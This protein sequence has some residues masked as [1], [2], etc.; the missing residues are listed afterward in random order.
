MPT[1][2]SNITGE[3]PGLLRDNTQKKE[4]KKQNETVD[5]FVDL[6][7]VQSKRLIRFAHAVTTSRVDAT[8][9]SA[10]TTGSERC[11]DGTLRAVTHRSDNR[12]REAGCQR[13]LRRQLTDLVWL[14]QVTGVNGCVCKTTAPTAQRCTTVYNCEQ[15]S[16]SKLR[17]ASPRS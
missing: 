13:L 12:P 8:S 7:E 1:R 3:W 5:K 2:S 9:L 14:L 6:V 11:G 10:V 15:H 4:A 16:E 17:T